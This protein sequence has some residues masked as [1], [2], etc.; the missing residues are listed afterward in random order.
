MEGLVVAA[1]CDPD[2][3]EPGGNHRL[4]KGLKGRNIPAQGRAEGQSSAAPPWVRIYQSLEALQGRNKRCRSDLTHE[5]HDL[6]LL[7]IVVAA[8][9]A[10]DL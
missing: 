2:R 6:R 8:F 10:L 3:G 4:R 5:E 9:Q 1:S 7:W